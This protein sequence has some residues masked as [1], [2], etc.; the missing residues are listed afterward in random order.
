MGRKLASEVVAI[1]VRGGRVREPIR[2]AA[3]AVEL[4][5]SG[6]EPWLAWEP[7][8][9]GGDRPVDG[10]LWAFVRLG[11][12][13]EDGDGTEEEIVTFAKA[14]G[15]LGGP[16]APTV[17]GTTAGATIRGGREPLDWWRYH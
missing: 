16:T 17:A 14:W 2:V 13:R 15:V 4:V 8:P 1:D 11:V 5:G 10:C 6:A 12:D 9:D 3:T 7:E